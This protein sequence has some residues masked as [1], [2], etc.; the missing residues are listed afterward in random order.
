MQ[1]SCAKK[2]SR[3]RHPQPPPRADDGRLI[4]ALIL[5]GLEAFE[6]SFRRKY[7]DASLEEIRDHMTN[8]LNERTRFE[9]EHPR[10]SFRFGR[11]N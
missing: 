11:H 4:K 7:P 5:K 3:S 1:K 10:R 9:Y 2:S 8:Y 6:E